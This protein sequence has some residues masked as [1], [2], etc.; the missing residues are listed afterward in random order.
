MTNTGS[1]AGAEVVQVY[2]GMKNSAVFRPNEELKALP[3]VFLEPRR[4]Q[5]VRIPLDDKG[6]PVF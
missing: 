6:I 5:T 1:L 3:K 2:V 4:I